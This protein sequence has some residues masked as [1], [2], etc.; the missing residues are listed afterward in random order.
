MTY[1]K[2]IV[3]V[4]SLIRNKYDLF[5]LARTEWRGWE[6]PGGQVEEGEDIISAL[7]REVLE[8]TRVHIEIKKLSAIYSSISEP[9][10]VI[11]DF[12]SEYR[13]GDIKADNEILDVGWFSRE[14]ILA[15]VE[16]DIMKYRIRWLLENQNNI[17]LAS[18]GKDPFKVVSEILFTEKT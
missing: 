18:Y 17:R 10:K 5:L 1:P 8:E 11:L 16:S 7:K 12:F 15:I 2:H 13:G 14:E 6:M 3:A 4:G 9:P